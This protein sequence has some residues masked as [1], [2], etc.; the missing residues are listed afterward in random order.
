MS[1]W[2][3]LTEIEV[4]TEAVET[5]S[6][7]RAVRNEVADIAGGVCANATKLPAVLAESS[8]DDNIMNIL[9]SFRNTRWSTFQTTHLNDRDNDRIIFRFLGDQR[10][11][12]MKAT[13]FDGHLAKQNF[14][15]YKEGAHDTT[16]TP[17]G[18]E[19]VASRNDGMQ[20]FLIE[21]AGVNALFIVAH[22][23]E[24][25]DYTKISEVEVWGC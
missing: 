25:G 4:C 23:N 16:W 24:K 22:G 11:S 3:A 6:G 8:G 19:R 9:D 21:E 10:V 17:I 5:D 18:D 14:R 7:V 1:S 20:T 13:F 15:L 12:Y 2:T